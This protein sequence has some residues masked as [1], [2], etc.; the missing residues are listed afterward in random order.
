MIIDLLTFFAIILLLL[1]TP[2][3]TFLCITRIWRD[4]PALQRWI[5]AIGISLAFY[6]VLFYMAREIFPDL[7]LG[8]RKLWAVLILF[9]IITMVYFWKERK[10]LFH[11]QPLEWVAVMI[12]AVTL[13]TRFWAIADISY[14]AWSDALHHVLITHLTAQNGQLP[15]TLQPFAPTPLDMY[16]LGLYSLTGSA[17]ILTKLPAHT[18]FLWVSQF[19]NGLCGLGVYLIL[20]RKVGR[21]GALVGLLVI[22]LWSLQPAW[23][24]NWS[25]TTSLAANTILIIAALITWEVLDQ[26][27]TY[28]RKEFASQMTLLAVAGLMNAGVFLYHFRVAGYYLPLLVVIGVCLFIRKY[29]SHQSLNYILAL[30]IIAVISIAL[31]APVLGR[32]LPAYLE[33]KTSGLTVDSNI[34]YYG[35]PLSS[36]F[37]IGAQKWLVILAGGMLLL[38]LTYRNRFSLIIMIWIIA[39]G[40]EAYLYLLNIPSLMFTNASGIAVI[41]YMPIALIIGAGAGSMFEKLAQHAQKSYS[42]GL[43]VILILSGIIAIPQRING[44]EPYRFFMTDADIPAMEWIKSNIPETAVFAINT[45]MWLGESPHGTDGG[46]WIPY[47]TGRKT[48]ASTMLFS[49][50]S[51]EEVSRVIVQSR[52]VLT[53]EG[54]EPKIDALCSLGINYLYHGQKGNFSS[55][56][57]NFDLLIGLPQTEIVYQANGVLIMKLCSE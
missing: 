28:S 27:G 17:E 30:F 14:P 2:G 36:I 20:D 56:G 6:P 5:A 55:D 42:N 21:K 3:F 18:T 7:H 11:L 46:Y 10:S 23:Y 25:R 48:N 31:I 57:F 24:V 19:L 41:L 35:M 16:H 15:Y 49:L 12:I 37:Q 40:V 33:S 26:I 4:W 34:N 13:F 51:E 38:G 22:G 32:A 54:E 1:L 43:M 53:L 44:I 45:Y 9:G 50:G 39:L 29:R 47:F 8:A 52:Y